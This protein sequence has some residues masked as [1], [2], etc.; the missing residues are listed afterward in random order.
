LAFPDPD[1]AERVP[2]WHEPSPLTTKTRCSP[3]PGGF[4]LPLK[5][6]D[7]SVPR[8]TI[9]TQLELALPVARM[10]WRWNSA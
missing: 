1:N 2:T 5:M 3:P 10:I 9:V 4:G 8:S 6:N 7:P